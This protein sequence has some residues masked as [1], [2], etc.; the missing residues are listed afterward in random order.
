MQGLNC[1]AQNKSKLGT[2]N[3]GCGRPIPAS[4]AVQYPGAEVD[5][6]NTEIVHTPMALMHQTGPVASKGSMQVG[7]AFISY[8]WDMLS[9]FVVHGFQAVSY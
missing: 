1:I 8:S 6:N 7:K 2:N 5:R 9:T 3:F 4:D